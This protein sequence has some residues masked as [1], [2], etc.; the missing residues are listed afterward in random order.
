MAEAQV[1]AMLKAYKGTGRMPS[2]ADFV[3]LHATG[4]E[5]PF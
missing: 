5:T 3:E 1:D 4:N 2:E